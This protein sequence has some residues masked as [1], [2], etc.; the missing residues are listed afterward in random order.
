MQVFTGKLLRQGRRSRLEPIAGH[1]L[2]SPISLSI[3]EDMCT[4]QTY[5]TQRLPDAFS[6]LNRSNT[7]GCSCQVQRAIKS[8]LCSPVLLPKNALIIEVWNLDSDCP[9][10]LRLACQLSNQV[11]LQ[12]FSAHTPKINRS[13]TMFLPTE[14]SSK[15]LNR[16]PRGL[17]NSSKGEKS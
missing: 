6:H 4:R 14:P 10:I 16:V 8:A 7:D 13:M 12:S 9:M 17:S 11:L 3:L 2:R 5:P 15:D 1:S